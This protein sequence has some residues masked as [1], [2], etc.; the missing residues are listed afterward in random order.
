MIWKAILWTGY[1][2]I[3]SDINFS[4]FLVNPKK[5]YIIK[6]RIQSEEQEIKNCHIYILACT[7]SMQTVNSNYS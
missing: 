5:K 3:K 7:G 6:P 1:I 2:I 4:G